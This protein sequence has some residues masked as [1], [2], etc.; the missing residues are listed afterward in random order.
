MTIQVI[1]TT[2]ID[3]SRN[4]INI[5]NQDF[6]VNGG[7]A[8]QTVTSP[9]VG[10]YA[11]LH[12]TTTVNDR[13]AA[14]A[15]GTVTQG[16]LYAGSTLTYA[17]IG[18]ASNSPWNSNPV[19]DNQQNTYAGTRGSVTLSGQWRAHGRHNFTGITLFLRVT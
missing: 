7:L 18:G 19:N 17:G 14:I 11:L 10:T 13:N 3:S 16:N 1:G 9:G 8:D 6:F 12:R 5:A 15:N 2:V 4:L